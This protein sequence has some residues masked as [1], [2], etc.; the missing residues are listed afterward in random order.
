MDDGLAS[1]CGGIR[2]VKMGLV[3]LICLSGRRKLATLIPLSGWPLSL[4]GP[5]VVEGC[6]SLIP[7]GS[8][9]SLQRFGS[10]L[11]F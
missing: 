11:K 7:I 6:G 3:G 5:A 10:S 8:I 2:I 4:E 1:F 9:S